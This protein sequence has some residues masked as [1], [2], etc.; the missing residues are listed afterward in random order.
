[1]LAGVS[2][3]FF[4]Y[5][6]ISTAFCAGKKSVI[7]PHTR[8]AELEQTVSQRLGAWLTQL[9]AQSPQRADQYRSVFNIFRVG[10][11]SDELGEV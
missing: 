1:M 9:I 4:T 2:V 5:P 11:T 7:Y 3:R 6:P 8:P 10:Q